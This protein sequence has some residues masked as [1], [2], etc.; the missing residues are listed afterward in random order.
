MFSLSPSGCF[1][2]YQHYIH[3]GKGIDGLYNFIR[4][5]RIC[6]FRET[7]SKVGLPSGHGI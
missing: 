6:I 2:L 7:A 4:S 5:K 3:I 1:Y